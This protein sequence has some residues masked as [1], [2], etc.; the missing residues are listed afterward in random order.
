M[1]CAPQFRNTAYSQQWS[2]FTA[3][4][5]PGEEDRQK[6]ALKQKQF[7]SRRYKAV[8]ASLQGQV[9]MESPFLT[10]TNIAQVYK[11]SPKSQ[12]EGAQ[13]NHKQ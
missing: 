9:E 7:K 4:V 3:K 12:R 1:F 6:A 13:L 5:T 10:I 8:P 2:A 11:N